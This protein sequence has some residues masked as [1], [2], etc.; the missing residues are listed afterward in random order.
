M[1]IFPKGDY[2]KERYLGLCWVNSLAWACTKKSCLQESDRIWASE[3]LANR[4]WSK[5]KVKSLDRKPIQVSAA[6]K[7][8]LWDCII[9]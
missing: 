6:V 9:E 3:A 2:G 8:L 5:V 7:I 1:L 4:S